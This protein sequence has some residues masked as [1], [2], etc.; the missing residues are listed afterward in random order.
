MPFLSLVIARALSGRNPLERRPIFAS[1]VVTIGALLVLVLW[2]LVQNAL[3]HFPIDIFDILAS[4]VGASAAVA[5]LLDISG[6]I[7][8]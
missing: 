7:R 2:E 4:I 8:L 6:K 3:W 1:V 5:I